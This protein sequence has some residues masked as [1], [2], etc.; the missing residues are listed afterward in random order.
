MEDQILYDILWYL[1]HYP[2][3]KNATDDV[4]QGSLNI[5]R[6]NFQSVRGNLLKDKLI[7]QRSDNKNNIAW[8]LTETG[9]QKFNELRNKRQHTDPKDFQKDEKSKDLQIKYFNSSIKANEST[10]ENNGK[11]GKRLLIG[12]SVTIFTVV[13][14]AILTYFLSK[15][16]QSKVST[17]QIQ[18]YNQTTHV[19]TISVNADSV[20]KTFF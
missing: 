18:I 3:E 1:N 9:Q 8:T 5:D 7:K 13:L 11:L 17:I 6:D 19:D 10:H 15:G 16:P 4:I 2:N 12:Y 14:G 20:K